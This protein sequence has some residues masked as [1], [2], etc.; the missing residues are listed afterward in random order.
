MVKQ[1]R[2]A[3]VLLLALTVLTGLVYPLLV[4]G[5][6]RGLFP[7][8]AQGSLVLRPDGTV[9]GSELIGQAFG[10][11]KY[12]QGRPSAAGKEGYDATSSGGSNLAV[13]SAA[14]TKSYEERIAALKE[15]NPEAVGAPPAD[16]VQA[17]GSGLD[18][19]ISPEAAYWQVARVAKVRGLDP[20]RVRDLVSAQVEGRTLGF[21]GEPR[22]NVL[23]LNLALDAV[24]Q[25]A[26]SR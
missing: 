11:P 23:R 10:D 19:H 5:L 9:V 24:T 4:T 25:G 2:P 8:Q 3:L 15:A 16:L 14:L 20:A 7:T 26:P 13:S 18:P 21:I 6:A 12:F 22:V 17:S 1:L